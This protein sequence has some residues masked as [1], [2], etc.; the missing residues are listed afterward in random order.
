MVDR[1][2]LPCWSF[3]RVALAG[4]AAHPIPLFGGNPISELL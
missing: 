3:G 1:D 4:D 2:P